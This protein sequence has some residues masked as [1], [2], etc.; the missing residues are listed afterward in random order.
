MAAGAGEGGG[1]GA[2]K[3]NIRAGAAG[4]GWAAN[5]WAACKR[6]RRLSTLRRLWARL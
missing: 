4:Y 2:G 5:T 3:A 1:A 6:R